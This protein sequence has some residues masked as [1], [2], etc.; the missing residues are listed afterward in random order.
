MSTTR[1]LLIFFG[2]AFAFTWTVGACMVFGHLRI[3]WSILASCGPTVAALVTN[4]L[5]NGNQGA[6]RINCSWRRT[7]AA[8]AIGVPLVLI[9]F[10][11]LPALATVDAAKL[12]WRALISLGMYN[13]STLLGGP[14]T[15]EPGWRG[16]A[17]PRLQSCFGPVPASL[18]LGTA[19]AAWHMP[20]FFYPGWT[21]ITIPTYFLIVIPLSVLLAWAAN[22]ARF[23]VIP[24]ILM[25]ACFNTS[26]KYFNGLFQ[27]AQPGSGGFLKH[28]PMNLT[29]SFAS[30]LA[31]GGWLVALVLIAFTR[32]R[33]ARSLEVPALTRVAAAAQHTPAHPGDSPA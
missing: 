4:R 19:W 2:L 13:Y 21:Q 10:I 31:M 5:A 16:F 3:E 28:V 25:H 29:L 26:G 8:G 22:L 33:L 17:L 20:F 32:G 1:Q 15:E 7:A 11:L 14:L 6:F 23:G 9:A 12:N 30:L 27:Y 24:A 18:I